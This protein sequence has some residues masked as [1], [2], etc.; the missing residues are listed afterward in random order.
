MLSLTAEGVLALEQ[1]SVPVGSTVIVLGTGTGSAAVLMSAGSGPGHVA[2][3]KAAGPGF[4][5]F[6]EGNFRENLARLT[7]KMP[8]DSHAHHVFPR[9]LAEEF[10]KVGI[11]VHD[12]RFGA[13]WNRTD[14]LKKAYEYTLQW[15]EFLFKNPTREQILHFGRYL[16][17]KY[18]FQI[19]Y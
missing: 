15:E 7:G 16:A 10:Q 2:A 6:T 19:N 3:G 1:I 17:N 11:N 18:G 8:A 14:H 4:K 13:W 5:P 9:L 12:P